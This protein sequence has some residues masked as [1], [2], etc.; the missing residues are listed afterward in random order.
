MGPMRTRRS[1]CLAGDP[2]VPENTFRVNGCDAEN[3][4]GGSRIVLVYATFPDMGAARGVSAGLVGQ[5]LAA[6]V[7]L[8]PGMR[9]VYRWDGAIQEDGEIAAL[10]KT[11][12]ALADRVMGFVRVAHPYRIPALLVL[13]AAGGHATFLDWIAMETASAVASNGKV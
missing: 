7:N 10:I 12:A 9:S 4:L 3:G 11:R 13:P 1:Y 8:I 2:Q 5:G 6:C